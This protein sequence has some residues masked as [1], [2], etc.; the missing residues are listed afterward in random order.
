ML[1]FAIERRKG[2][3][4]SRARKLFWSLPSPAFWLADGALRGMR[5]VV[6]SIWLLT[7]RRLKASIGP[8][9]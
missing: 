7:Q 9:G 8:E 2:G 3:F 6:G 4:T 1:G 5:Y